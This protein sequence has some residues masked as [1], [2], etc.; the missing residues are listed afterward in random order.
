[1]SREIFAADCSASETQEI[2]TQRLLANGRDLH[3]GQRPV[4]VFYRAVDTYGKTLDFML[5]ERRDEATTT[6]FSPASLR[7]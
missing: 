7:E 4:E 3:Q 6:D 2:K 1:M 5:S